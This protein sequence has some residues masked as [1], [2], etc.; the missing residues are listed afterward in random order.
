LQTFTEQQTDNLENVDYQKRIIGKIEGKKPGPTIIALAGVHGNEPTSIKAVEHVLEKVTGLED[1]FNGTFIGI[2]G[3][4]EALSKGE[5]FIDEDMN[6]IWFTSI[7]DKVRRT[8]FGEILTAER[9][10][11]KAVLEIIDPIILNENKNETVIFADLHTFSAETGLFAISSREKKNVDLLS[12]LNVPLI[13]GIEKA[14]HG[15][16]LKYIQSTGN[17]GFAFE[18]GM[19]FS[20]SAEFN[21]TAGIYAL[22]NASGCLDLSHIPDYEPYH[23]FLAQQTA[24][25]PKKVEFIYK[26]IIEEDDEFVM[27]P[28]FKNFD[29]IKKGDWL[30]NDKLGRI[31][32]QAEGYI[33]MPLYQEQGDDGF[34]I[35]KDLGD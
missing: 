1:K 12:K 35:V 20:E 27:R 19:H 15:T 14:L 8:P 17:I 2:R 22:L 34:F 23:D 3:N 30:A 31:E 18:A 29:K 32:A 16:A 33:L 10:E 11:T 9:R 26:H 4:L 25:L 28:G 7:L 24:G 6:R 13:F 21:A 5:R